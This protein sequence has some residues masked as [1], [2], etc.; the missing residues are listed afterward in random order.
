MERG[1]ERDLG[2][3]WGPGDEEQRSQAAAYGLKERGDS[4]GRGSHRGLRGAG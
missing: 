2:S 1:V 3:R 4:W